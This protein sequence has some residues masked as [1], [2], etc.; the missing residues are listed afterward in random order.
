MMPNGTEQA[1]LR[2]KPRIVH[3]SGF[4]P[5]WGFSFLA[6]ALCAVTAAA[7]VR[8]ERWRWSN[9][10][11]HGNNVLDMKVAG[12]L[13]LQV[14][15]AG[16]LYVQQSG[17]RWSPAHT[18][19]D[20]YL[21]STAFFGERM[22]ATGEAGMILWSD[23]GIDFHQAQLTPAN[24]MDWFE[25]VTASG[26][27]LV[28]VGDN[29]AIY[30]STNG[31]AWAVATS[32]TTE[33]LRGVASGGGGFVAVGETGTILR[34]PSNGT[35]W[36]SITSPTTEHLNRVRYLG[37][38]GSGRFYAVGNNGTLLKSDTGT[39]PWTSIDSGTTNHLYDV[40]RNNVG[41]LLVGDEELRMSTDGGA[42][43]TD[44]INEIPTNAPPT[45]TYLS[46]HG[47][48]DSW[49][50]AGRTGLLMEGSSTNGIDCI[51]QPSPTISSHA[52]LWDMTVQ[53][54]LYVAVG[55]LANIKTSLDGILWASEV[56]PVS[57]TNTV[58]LGVGGTSNLLVAVGNSGNVLISQAGWVDMTVTND[59]VVTNI[60]IQTLGVVW[61]NLTPFTT[62]SLQGID[63]SD[64]LLIITGADGSV[65]TSAD[66]T[67][68]TTRT[69]TTL[70]FLS[71][72]AIGD[73]VCVAVGADGTLIRSVDGGASWTPPISMGTTHWLYRVR[74]IGNQFVVVGENGTIFTSSDGLTWEQRTSGTERWLTDITFVDDQWYVS[75]Y[76][77]TLLTST[78]LVNWSEL[79]LP[80]GKSIFTAASKDGQLI[81]AGVEGVT[82]RNQV[83]PELSPVAILDYDYTMSADTNGL[84]SIYELFLFGGKPDQMFDFQSTTTWTK[85][86]LCVATLRSMRATTT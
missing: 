53:R 43:W 23:D 46:A 4:L 79:P 82:L 70:S 63:A 74:W 83:V 31:A 38:N 9:P 32:G 14:G 21:R 52:W 68:W 61:T 51:W 65:Y 62:G 20:N 29:G 60:P 64:D 5:I 47:K 66:G 16:A 12:D 11:P 34:S 28:A 25:G 59:A 3:L 78:N 86:S 71:S 54:G 40:A 48:G 33:W 67:N 2:Q 35:S 80:T 8:S 39:A 84:E 18:G 50:V 81:L 36:S 27:R 6:L 7:E 73:E 19:V 26:Q 58:L 77:G 85:I 15:D 1:H 37:S 49:L 30:T 75:G 57:R 13:A 45:W 44:Q 76:Q 42:N 10:L 56:V 17:G 22:V 69:T 72:V 55:D 24:T 41:L